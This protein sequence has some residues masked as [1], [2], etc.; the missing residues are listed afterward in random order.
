[1][2]IA[3]DKVNIGLIF[4]SVDA[5]IAAM[6]SPIPSPAPAPPTLLSHA[7]RRRRYY[8]PSHP[9]GKPWRERR[10][11]SRRGEAKGWKAEEGCRLVMCA[12]WLLLCVWCTFMRGTCWTRGVQPCHTPASPCPA[13][14]D[15]QLPRSSHKCVIGTAGLHSHPAHPAGRRVR[16]KGKAKPRA[17]TVLDGYGT[18]SHVS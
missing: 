6:P 16:Q 15:R 17:K 7:A 11:A 9:D 12:A 13:D 8:P 14:L 4:H 3:Y 5:T 1:M 10:A 18:H 2:S